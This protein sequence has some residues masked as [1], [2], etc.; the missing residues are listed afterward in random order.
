MMIKKYI[1]CF[2]IE[3]LK[4]NHVLKMCVVVKATLNALMV[5]INTLSRK[6]SELDPLI[7]QLYSTKKQFWTA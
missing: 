1:F 2:F 3:N 4:K 5:D 6:I 7:A